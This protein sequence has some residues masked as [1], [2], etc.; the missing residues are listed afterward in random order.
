MVMPII[1]VAM[2]VDQVDTGE[3]TGKGAKRGVYDLMFFF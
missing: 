1:S 3:S 2:Q